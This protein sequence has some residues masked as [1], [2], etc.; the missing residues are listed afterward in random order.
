VTQNYRS[1]HEIALRQAKGQ[2]ST[3]DLRRAMI[4]YR[5]LFDELVNERHGTTE[6]E[7]KPV[8]VAERADYPPET[9][10]VRRG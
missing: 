8:A 3:E 1:A 2:A 6:V 7:R 9:V 10:R 5:A 4:H